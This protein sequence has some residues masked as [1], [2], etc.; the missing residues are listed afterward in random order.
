MNHESGPHRGVNSACISGVA[1]ATPLIREGVSKEAFQTYLGSDPRLQAILAD[2]FYG[3]AV[4]RLAIASASYGFLDSVID[5]AGREPLLH[6][7]LFNCVVLGRKRVV[8]PA[9]D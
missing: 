4:R 3:C 1:A 9:E 7:A 2:L 8:T 5:L 6:R